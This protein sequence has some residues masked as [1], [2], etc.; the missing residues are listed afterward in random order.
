MASRDGNAIQVSPSRGFY[1][2]FD[3]DTT[4]AIPFTVRNGTGS[5]CTVRF[6]PP[7]NQRVFSINTTSV[8]LAPGLSHVIEAEFIT[9]VAQDYQDS[10]V[11]FTNNESVTVPLVAKCSPDLE[12][13][14]AV[15]FGRVERNRHGLSKV[16]RLTNKGRREKQVHI[17]MT[18][19]ATGVTVNPQQCVAPP[20]GFVDVY[21]ELLKLD[22]GFHRLP[23]RI[24][25]VGEAEHRTVMLEIEVMDSKGLLLDPR[26]ATEVHALNFAKTYSGTRRVVEVDVRNDSEQTVSFAFQVA[27]DASAEQQQQQQPFDFIPRQGRLGPHEITRVTA[28]FSPP[29]SYSPNGWSCRRENRYALSTTYE[30]L[31]SLLF[32]EMEHAHTVRVIGTSTTTVAWLSQA[33]VDFGQCAMNDYRDVTVTVHNG[34]KE[35]P[36][37]FTFPR[38]AHFLIDPDKGEVKPGASCDVRLSFRPRRLGVFEEHLRVVFNETEKENLTLSGVVKSLVPMPKIIGGVDKLPEDFV[39]VQK[40]VRLVRESPRAS[41][42]PAA[43]TSVDAV[44]I[45]M[46]PAEGLQPPE[47]ELPTATY[48]R[49]SK[50][51]FSILRGPD[52]FSPVSLDAKT[53]IRKVFKETPSNVMERRDCRRELQPMEF[54]RI[55]APIKVMDY[56]RVTVGSTSIKTFFLYNGTD[57]AVLAEMPTEETHVSFSPHS[58]VIPAGRAA[59]YDV[60]FCSSV[61]QTYQQIVQIKINGRYMLRFTVQADVV[62]VEVTLSRDDV[63]L[64]FTDFAD[65]SIAHATVTLFNHGNSEAAYTWSLNTGPFAIEPTSGSIAPMSK[66][67]AQLTFSPPQ[68]VLNA[69][70]TAKLHVKGAL[71]TRVLHLKGIIAP[72]L[73]V[74]STAVGDGAGSAMSITSGGECLLKLNQVPAGATTKAKVMLHNKGRNSALFSFE[75]IPDWLTVTPMCRHVGVGETEEITLAVHHDTPGLVQASLQCCVRGMKRPLKLGLTAEVCVAP[76]SIISPS[77]SIGEIFLEFDSVYIGTEKTLP[78]RFCNSGDVAAV[79]FVDLRNLPEYSLRCPNDGAVSLEWKGRGEPVPGEVYVTIPPRS[80]AGV[81]VVYRPTSVGNDERFLVVWRHIGTDEMNP[82]MPLV[83]SARAVVSKIVVRQQ[84]FEFPRTVI[85]TTAVPLTLTI[86][87]VS[88]D[89]VRWELLLARD[90]NSNGDDKSTAGEA[91]PF[92]MNPESGTLAPHKSQLVHVTF[93]PNLEGDRHERYCV[94]LDGNHLRPCAEVRVSGLAALPCIVCDRDELIFPAVPLNVVVQE[95]M[96][97]ANDGFD[98]I[99]IRYSNKEAGPLRVTFPHGAIFK[100]SSRIPVCVEF[101]SPNPVSLS[102][103]ITFTTDVGETLTIPVTATA[104]NSFLTTA[105]YVM[106]QRGRSHISVAEDVTTGGGH[107]EVEQETEGKEEWLLPFIY[108]DDISVFPAGTA[109]A[110]STTTAPV[111][112]PLARSVESHLMLTPGPFGFVD[113]VGRD[114]YSRRAI[115]N[116]QMWLNQCIFQKPV[117]DLIPALQSTDGR[118]LLEAAYRISGKRPSKLAQ[119]SGEER[120]LA[121]LQLLT[122]LIK[123]KGGCLSDV[124]LQYLMSYSAYCSLLEGRSVDVLPPSVFA[125]RAD[126]AWVTVILQFIRVF[127]LPKVDLTAMLQ[128]YPAM[129][130]Y[131]PRS[132]W[133]SALFQAALR[134]SNVFS[135][136]EGLLLRW[137]SYNMHRCVKAGVVKSTT[138]VI[139]GFDD[140]RDCLGVLAC[141]LTYVPSAATRLLPMERL[142]AEPTT[143]MEM[144]T[145]AAVLLGALTYIGFP[146]QFTPRE[147]L[148][149]NTVDWLLL[150]VT[151]FIFLPRFIPSAL[152]SLEGKLLFPMSRSVEVANTSNTER[153]YTVE[154][155]NPAFRALPRE[156][157]VDAGGVVQLSVEVTLRFNRRVE[158][159]CVVVDTSACLMEE[160]APM[161]FRLAAMPNDEPLRVVHIQ[162]PLYTALQ[163]EMLVESPFQESCVA[164]LRFAQEYKNDAA[165]PEGDFGKTLHNAF[166]ISAGVVPFHRG[167]KTKVMIQFVPCARGTYEARITFHDEQ[168]GEF[169]Y[170][171]VGTCTS[172]KVTDKVSVRAESGEECTHTFLVKIQN[173]PFERMLRSLGEHRRTPVSHSAKT[174]LMPDLVGVPYTVTFVN[175]TNIG[176]NP[177]YRG[178]ESITFVSGE[179]MVPLSF[180]FLPKQLGE[181]NGYILLASKYDVRSIQV[182]GKCVPTGEKGVIRFACPA[183]QCITQGL[184]LNNKSNENWL[185]TA[186]V[187]GPGFSGPKELCVPRG[188]QREYLLRYSPAWISSAKGNLTLFNNETGE[189]CTY[190]LIGEAEEPLS[191]DVLIIECRARERHTVPLIVPDVNG[192]DATYHVETDLPFARGGSSVLVHR[193]S[194]ARYLLVL[195]P[196]MG[197]TYSGTVVCRAPNGRYAW[198]AVTVNVSPPEKEGTVEIRTDTRT[199][200]TADVS[201][202]NTTD[203]ALVFNVRG[204]GPGLFGENSLLVEAGDPAVYSLLFVPSQIGSFDGRLAFYSDEAGEFWYELHIIV[205]EAAS[206]EIAFESEIG[207]PD[208]RQVRIPNNT[209]VER[210]LYVSNTNSRN[211]STAPALLMIPPYSELTV[212]IVY[213]PTAVEK[214]QESILKLY[215]PDLGEWRYLCRGV[216]LQPAESLPVECVC[217][218]G[219]KVSV[220]LKIKNPF[221]APMIPNVALASDKEGYYALTT[222]TQMPCIAPGAET[223]ISLIYTPR[224]VGHHEATVLVRPESLTKEVQDVTW[225]FP[226]RGVAEWRCRDAPLRFRCV[227]RRQMEETITL[228]PSGLTEEEKDISMVLEL[229]RQQQY[230]SAVESSFQTSLDASKRAGGLLTVNVRFAPLRPFLATADLVVRSDKGA[231]WRYSV[232]LDAVRAEVDDVVTIK[233]APRTVSAVTFAMYNVFPH[234]SPFSAYFTPESSRDLS[235]INTRGVLHPFLVGQRSPGNATPLQVRFAP[236]ARLPQ[237]EGTLIVD[238]EDMQWSFKVIGKLEDSHMR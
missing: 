100:S 36:L 191:E 48:K 174:F 179:S 145:N 73:C 176:P 131:L 11:V 140:L 183:R 207:V 192:V 22:V 178:P 229:E 52:H 46:I 24:D 220:T 5:M 54:L 144:E 50:G 47:P 26:T 139:R 235:V 152:L 173:V 99:E 230:A 1:V 161:V 170:L 76:L 40:G 103:S 234:S 218:V 155:D 129:K 106:F 143:Q 109:A 142:I 18:A 63:V 212:D 181:Y 75:S 126:H 43:A 3:V 15:N 169:S 45:G 125:V 224:S 87:N 199:P 190:T 171:V 44:D 154:M 168:K 108:Y 146:A 198:Y 58:Q 225:R 121:S 21:L 57:A 153:V 164:T 55:A 113:A 116:L 29:I 202:H 60:S 31:Y 95:T 163:Y 238:T 23:L 79:V 203:K 223:A 71:A 219:G 83:I 213:T 135:P 78:V 97:I 30:T 177:F 187:E 193:G 105:P 42:G 96:Y 215:N 180:S 86:E 119:P 67:T 9:H 13:P 33:V 136:E 133:D 25:V 10:F 20:M 196:M 118:P 12:F 53:L 227:A 34:H 204:F 237:V 2:N 233:A 91:S 68:G 151:L 104:I 49:K 56:Q 32:L 124:R 159:E 17:V 82:L 236:S 166:N 51:G 122:S 175:E 214:P 172:P 149:Y 37:Q 147:L 217:E 221:D 194:T 85:G 209:A 127:Y 59:A 90:E 66:V 39:S 195:H 115:E 128:L 41:A 231:V 27:G 182:T 19:Q 189:R 72:T 137:V 208:V 130:K 62:P 185:I 80:E 211:F 167:E 160:R 88:G 28:V 197:G 210:N 123:S 14:E 98:S 35:M 8:R 162:T 4:Y 232:V 81:L 148:E 114:V 84:C 184:H 117:S 16:L 107:S 188:K 201:I 102:T 70:T 61:V 156:F 222:M 157:S 134:D 205:E 64:N 92:R 7:S 101:C 165:Y 69:E 112:Y 200:V 216:G 226:L 65:D 6:T 111:S 120:S 38:V 158:G 110:A 77:R 141:I 132:N 74:W 89:S 186:T 228:N 206:E 138:R 150:V 94:Y 93:V